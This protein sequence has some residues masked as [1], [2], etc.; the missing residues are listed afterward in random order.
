MLGNDQQNN[1]KFMILK[2]RTQDAEKHPISPYFS[3]NTKVDDKWAETNQV[4]K[5]AGT[6]NKVEISKAEWEG[7]EYDVVKLR[8]TDDQAGEDYLLDLRLNLL[9]RSIFNSL[10]SLETFGDISISLYQKRGEK[11]YPAVSVKQREERVDWKFKLDE[12]PKMEKVTVGKKV[13][14]DA[15]VL[16]EFY[17][18]NLEEL[19]KRVE[20]PDEVLEEVGDSGVNPSGKDERVPF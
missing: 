17:L 19:K 11:A 20:G 5:L 4:T 1:N 3:V 6:L 9:S 2:I 14:V 8:F 13:V 18:A 7:A 15:T 16:D 10:F 12:Q